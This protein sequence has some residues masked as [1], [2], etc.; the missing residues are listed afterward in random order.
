MTN[1]EAKA[2][3]IG[4]ASD[5]ELKHVINLQLIKLGVNG[6]EMPEQ[7]KA[8]VIKWLKIHWK[9]VTL[10]QF[11]SA[12]NL[13]INQQLD[14]DSSCYGKF[15]IEYCGKILSAWLKHAK[16]SGQIQKEFDAIRTFKEIEFDRENQ[17]SMK[18][19]VEKWV[20]E[21]KAKKTIQ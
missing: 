13:A 20:A 18:D 19:E 16:N 14:V 10:F 4:E 12:F 7:F 8:L 6:S 5:S 11:N 1:R 17:V 21:L 9:W 3:K 2:I 15:T